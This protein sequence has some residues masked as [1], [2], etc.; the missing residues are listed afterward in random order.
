MYYN[1][2][3]GS[4]GIEWTQSQED[5]RL[6][7]ADYAV[8]HSLSQV[9]LMDP[10]TSSDFEYGWIV[11]PSVYLDAQPHLFVF[12]FD[13]GVQTPYNYGFVPYPGSPPLAAVLS[14]N[15]YYHTYI[16]EDSGGNWW[17]YHDGY[18]LGYVPLSVWAHPI[19]GVPFVEQGG[20]VASRATQTACDVMGSGTF[21]NSGVGGEAYWP[22]SA[23]L[24][25]P[26]AYWFT[27]N[28]IPY[29]T[30]PGV[31]NFGNANANGGFG[32]GGPGYSTGCG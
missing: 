26:S 1:V 4:Y 20:E 29:V 21:G 15:D 18:W 11:A 5:P 9:W 23:I 8:G 31:W 12:H 16:A 14:H 30:D 17:V 6:N 22:W 13:G 25:Y 19:T 7:P 2:L 32:Y 27:P 24:A 3:P 10:S 28:E